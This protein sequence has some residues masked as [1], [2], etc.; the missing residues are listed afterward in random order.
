MKTIHIDFAPRSIRRAVKRT[1]PASWALAGIGLVLC[2]SAAVV[3][4]KLTRQYEA[5]Q[6]D[7]LRVQARTVKIAA[8]KPVPQKFIIP[9]AQAS[10]VNRAIAQLNLP[11]RD[12]F[13]A[14]EAATPA[15]I[16]LLAMEPD[17]KRQ[18]IHGLAEAKTSDSMIAYIEE[19]KKQAF[20]DSVILTRHEINAQDPNKPIR[21]QFEATWAELQQ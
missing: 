12:V 1:Q 16:A 4:L 3:A 10:A 15:T 6:A 19:L 11:W 20:F 14:I 9:D 8:H 2:I 13:D 18:L 21:F 5:L 7:R 17:A